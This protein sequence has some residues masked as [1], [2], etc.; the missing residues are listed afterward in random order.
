[1]SNRAKEAAHIWWLRKNFENV[2]MEC[3]NFKMN[4]GTLFTHIKRNRESERT[5]VSHWLL[6]LAAHARKHTCQWAPHMLDLMFG[7]CSVLLFHVKAT[8]KYFLTSSIYAV[9][10]DTQTHTHY[11][12]CT[13]YKLIQRFAHSLT[14]SLT[15]KHTNTHSMWW[16]NGL[17]WRGEKK[18]WCIIIHHMDIC[19]HKHIYSMCAVSEWYGR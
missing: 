3:V 18:E 6:M 1:M 16:W 19:I 11:T 17:A 12:Q 7:P 13:L 14:Y 15:Q 2:V 8:E 10:I 9:Y 5:T 4:D